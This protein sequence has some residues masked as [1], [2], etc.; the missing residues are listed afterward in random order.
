MILFLLSDAA[1]YVTGQT[2]VIDGG[3]SL[4]Q[5]QTDALLRAL[6]GS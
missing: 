3:S 5:L 2:V 6:S 1:P 4:P